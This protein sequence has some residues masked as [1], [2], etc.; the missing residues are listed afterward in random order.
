[1]GVRGAALASFVGHVFLEIRVVTVMYRSLYVLT[2]FHSPFLWN[3]HLAEK[4]PWA[5]GAVV[6][7]VSFSWVLYQRIVV[8]VGGAPVDRG[9]GG[10]ECAGHHG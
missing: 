9:G 2:V 1:M 6:P 10:C 5:L 4:C 8:V 3:C 7:G